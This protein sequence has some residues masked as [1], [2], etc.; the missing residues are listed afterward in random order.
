MVDI[1]IFLTLRLFARSTPLALR[2]SAVLSSRSRLQQWGYRRFWIAEHHN[3]EAV[4]SAATAL[5]ISQIA[6]ATKSIRVGAGGIML[7]TTPHSWLRSNLALWMLSTQEGLTLA[8]GVRRAP[9]KL[10]K[11][12]SGAPAGASALLR[13]SRNC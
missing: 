13:M 9:T 5:V 1:S 7:R 3:N 10:A 4:A 11:R 2:F 6:A 12:P 8:W